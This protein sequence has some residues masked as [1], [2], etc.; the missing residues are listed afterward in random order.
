M[1]ECEEW[2]PVCIID[3]DWPAFLEAGR[4]WSTLYIWVQH[5]RV[6]LRGPARRVDRRPAVQKLQACYK[7]YVLVWRKLNHVCCSFLNKNQESIQLLD[8]F[9]PRHFF[10]CSAS[11]VSSP[12]A[13]GKLYFV[14]SCI[15]FGIKASTATKKV[16]PENHINV[17]VI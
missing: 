17:P 1:N 7:C 12:D 11:T 6:Q 16:E 9:H 15:Y 10:L 13:S 8:T 5:L 3:P 4:S 14:T 2:K